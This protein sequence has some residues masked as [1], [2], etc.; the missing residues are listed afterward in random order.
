MTP[1]S[2]FRTG[3]SNVDLDRFQFDLEWL[4]R[5]VRAIRI[6]KF[7]ERERDMA[8][9]IKG[10]KVKALKARANIDALNA[11][12]D[13]FNEAAPRHAADVDG[14]ASQ[15]AGMQDDLEF[16]AN[17]LGNSTSEQKKLD[18]L[19]PPPPEPQIPVEDASEAT[20]EKKELFGALF[21]KKR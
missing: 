5:G 11:A 4:T 7:G 14:L 16:A 10:L 1:R 3:S 8:I 19:P 17:V 2:C 18:D 20:I 21:P 15:V 9:E 13:K 6:A 12:Y